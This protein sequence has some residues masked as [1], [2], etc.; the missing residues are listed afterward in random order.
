[1]IVE[2]EVNGLKIKAKKGEMLLEALATNGIHVPTLCNMHG[3]RPTGA[4]R[5]C[6]VEAEGR[7]DLIPACSHPVEEWMKIQTHSARVIQARRSILE[8]LLSRHPDGCLSCE[9]SRMCELQ[10][11]ALELNIHEKP[12]FRLPVRKKIDNTSPVVIRDPAKCVL[13]S[14]CV[15]VCEEQQAATALDFV[16]RGSRIEVG[17]ILDKGLN[18]SSCTGCGQC[19][20][21]CPT[22]ALKERS[23]IDQVVGEL[24][25]SDKVMVAIIDP[26]VMVSLNE[27]FGLKSGR[28]FNGVFFGALKKIGFSRVYTPFWGTEAEISQSIDVFTRRKKDGHSGPLY[29]ATCPAFVQYVRQNRPDILPDL[30]GVKTGSQL[31]TRILK[32]LYARQSGH[33]IEGVTVVSMTAC[34]AVKQVVAQCRNLTDKG[35][36]PDFVLT[37]REVYRL[38]RL[39]G[40][41]MGTGVDDMHP[42]EIGQSV[43]SGFLPAVSGGCLEAAIRILESQSP[44]YR[45]AGEKSSKLRGLKEIKECI[46]ESD[47]GTI[48]MTAVSGLSAFEAWQSQIQIKKRKTD[49]VEVMACPGGCLNGGGQPCLSKDRNLRSRMKNLYEMDNLYSGISAVLIRELP[50]DFSAEPDFF[51]TGFSPREILK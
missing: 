41:D 50:L 24:Q 39:F 32:E 28:E 2:I 31:T 9:R 34:T 30:I 42:D 40:I 33:R 36:Q 45:L 44:G 21:V 29:L 37:T 48:S 23:H 4:C 22:G 20:L 3:F 15:R 49:L 10:D 38:I 16:R 25:N 46:C 18:Y 35:Y 12:I 51:F 27:L 19:I 17:T 14:R 5:L 1:M 26:A 47:T 43:R 7:D 11:L 6:V 13:C 8:L